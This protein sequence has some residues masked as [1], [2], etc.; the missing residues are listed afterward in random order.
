MLF[1]EIRTGIGEIRVERLL[2]S[3]QTKAIALFVELVVYRLTL[4][5]P[6]V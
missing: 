1:E 3:V 6:H 5:S 2:D 4:F